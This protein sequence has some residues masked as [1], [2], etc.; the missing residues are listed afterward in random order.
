ML[1]DL[2]FFVIDMDMR[3]REG[4]FGWKSLTG[5]FMAFSKS[6]SR[7]CK[8]VNHSITEISFA[9]GNVKWLGNSPRLVNLV[10]LQ[11]WKTIGLKVTCLLKNMCSSCTMKWIWNMM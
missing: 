2:I 5:A 7:I 3:H 9:R 6:L 8:P 1:E 10:S 11:F 4:S